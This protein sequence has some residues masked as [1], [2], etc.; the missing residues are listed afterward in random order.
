MKKHDDTN[1]G[2]TIQA[3]PQRKWPAKETWKQNVVLA[4]STVLSV[5][6]LMTGLVP[7]SRASL[8]V[9]SDMDCVIEPSASIEL[10]SAVSGLIA[11]SYYDRSDYVA[12][13]TVMAQLE[14]DVERVTLAI[15]EESASSSTA[16]ELRKLTAAFGERTHVRNQK[17]LKTSGVSRQVID[18]MST[19]ARI[20][21]LQVVQ[22]QESVRL[23]R[24]EVV[25]A[26]ASLARRE[27]RSPI[28]GSVVQAYKSAGEYVDGDPVYQI[29]QLDPLHVE[30]IVPIEYLGNLST[31]MTAAIRI[32]VPGFENNVLSGEVRRIDA[33]ADAASATYGVRLI[34]ENPDMKIPSGVRCQIDFLAS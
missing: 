6:A 15:A 12:K 29:A 30:V 27:I 22:E 1:C 17:L 2:L 14:S 32:D 11:A 19:E 20:A 18:Q 16:V 34:L 13:G 21:A 28:S 7:S 4:F 5:G 9:L 23:A 26:K 3:H 8:E 24:L 10:G 31:G 25:R 33:V